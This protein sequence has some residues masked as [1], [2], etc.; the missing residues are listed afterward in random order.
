MIIDPLANHFP[1]AD[2]E[3]QL[4]ESFLDTECST[5]TNLFLI[6]R[7]QLLQAINC[8]FTTNKRILI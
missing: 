8:E 7:F 2:H 1:L 5:Q 3:S 6:Q 4:R